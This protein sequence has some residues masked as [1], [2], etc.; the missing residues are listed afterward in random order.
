MNALLGRAGPKGCC[1]WASGTETPRLEAASA[2][3]LQAGDPS[4]RTVKGILAGTRGL[5]GRPC[6]AIASGAWSLPLATSAGKSCAACRSAD[7]LAWTNVRLVR[8]DSG[9]GIRALKRQSA[10]PLRSIGSITL[11]KTIIGLGLVD[12]LRVVIFPADPRGRWP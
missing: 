9:E 12:R 11:V 4:Y 8:G 10:G 6:P 2:R 7:S 5:R 1:G 3:A